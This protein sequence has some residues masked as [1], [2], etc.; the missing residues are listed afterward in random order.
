M[1]S[2]V[3]T[4]ERVREEYARSVKEFAKKVKGLDAAGIPAPHIP[5][6]G[7]SYDKCSYKI[8]FVGMETYGWGN[9]ND[10]IALAE[11]SP[12]DA[13]TKYEGWFDRGGMVKHNGSA[14]FWGFILSFLAKFYHVDKKEL[15]KKNEDGTYKE[16]LSSI[17][18]GNSNAIERYEVTAKKKGVDLSVWKEVKNLSKSFDSID[19]IIRTAKPKVI[20]LTYKKVDMQY[21][22]Q[23]SDIKKEIPDTKYAYLLKPNPELDYR[24]YYLREQDTHV[25]VIPHPTWIGAYSGI[26]FD[27]YID[28]LMR[29]IENLK[30]WPK[31]PEMEDDWKRQEENRSSSEYKN[32]FIADLAHFLVSKGL[33]MTGEELQV[34][35]NKNNIRTSYGSKYSEDGGRG[36]HRVIKLAWKYYHNKGQYQVA[37][38]ISR[39]F[40]GKNLKYT[41]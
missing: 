24:Y 17:I 22:L 9:M 16:I 29:T 39:A 12:K 23:D 40:V 6:V 31:L 19:H 20:F 33:V 32:R 26:G 18:W 7:D 14:T 27:A 11:T 35:F 28:D 37:L 1:N 25:F 8:A 21:V 4:R 15:L 36:I 38:D 41:Y 2:Q 30:I 13:V 34:L 3:S 5:I 10:F